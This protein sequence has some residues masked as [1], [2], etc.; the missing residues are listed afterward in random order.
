MSSLTHIHDIKN[1]ALWRGRVV[2]GRFSRVLGGPPEAAAKPPRYFRPRGQTLNSRKCRP[3][4]AFSSRTKLQQNKY[5][6]N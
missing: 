1:P 2:L 6:I 3:R 4:L 5:K